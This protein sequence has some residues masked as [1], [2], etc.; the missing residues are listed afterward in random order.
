MYKGGDRVKFATCNGVG[1]VISARDDADLVL[2]QWESGWTQAYGI[3]S[4]FLERVEPVAA[5]VYE[6]DGDGD[7]ELTLSGCSEWDIALCPQ[8]DGMELFDAHD[9]IWLDKY[10]DDDCYQEHVDMCAPTLTASWRG[11]YE[12][13]RDDMFAH[14]ESG[15][16]EGLSLSYAVEL[17]DAA[18]A[19]I[20]PPQV[21]L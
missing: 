6:M 2:V 17:W 10:A 3:D 18:I 12:W 13:Q 20:N 1:T 7:L 15:F 19:T 4:P 9:S 8:W 21:T 16:Y 11:R 5:M 14:Y